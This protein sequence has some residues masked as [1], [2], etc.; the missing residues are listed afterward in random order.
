MHLHGLRFGLPVLAASLLLGCATASADE[1]PGRYTMTP[2]EGGFVRLDTDT[3]AVSVCRGKEGRFTCEPAED[4]RLKLQRDIDRLSRE[5]ED[6]RAEVRRLQAEVPGGGK[7]AEGPGG[8]PSEEEVDKALNYFER[9]FRKFRDK[10]RELER[11][12]RKGTPM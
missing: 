11:E 9:M 1:R 8:L 2:T 12:D 10:L 3:G 6:L 5:N 7:R 4:N